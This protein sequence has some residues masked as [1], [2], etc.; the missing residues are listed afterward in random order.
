MN[1][2]A[3]HYQEITAWSK[4]PDFK[5]GRAKLIDPP[6]DNPFLGC[7][8]FGRTYVEQNFS[9]ALVMMGEAGAEIW[10][11]KFKD[12]YARAEYVEAWECPNEFPVGTAEQRR[13]A[14]RFLLR[15]EKLMH[16]AG[17]KTV[18]LCTSVSW[19]HTEDAMEF[20]P[21]LAA[22]EYLGLHEYGYPR[23]Q[24]DEV[25]TKCLHYRQL[26]AAWTAGGVKRIPPILITEC[27]ED[28]GRGHGWK[29][30]T[31]NSESTFLADLQ[32]Y[33]DELAKD[34]YLLAFFVFT[35]GPQG[36]GD[37]EITET[38]GKA[39]ASPVAFVPPDVIAP[40]TPTPI[41]AHLMECHLARPLDVHLYP[42][43]SQWFG[44]NPADYAKFNLSGHDGIDYPAPVG[45]P[46]LAA[47]A[48][49]VEQ[50]GFDAAG[51]GNFV[52]LGTPDFVTIYA[53]LSKVNVTL[54][55]PVAIGAK[56]GEVGWTGNVSPAGPGG[57]HLH[58][59]VR[60]KNGV[61]QAY[62]NWWD[63]VPFRDIWLFP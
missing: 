23:M 24:T 49:S 5:Q 34:D 21:V 37:F 59:A 50:I 58:F 27:G 61:N 28:D 29:T 41:G 57:A 31:G 20:A 3:L 48:G 14:V 26:V 11:A 62:L 39:I 10:F 12:Q 54:G 18:E 55:Q 17:Y 4:K 22:A 36:W 1:K 63:V 60:F 43:V 8:V 30:A 52:K 44:V 40:P 2:G 6:S 35:A 13:M 19:L 25:G 47:H 9:N 53:H 38:L 51:Y 33:A 42:D 45:A 15:W 56:L 16:A 46:V 7:Q 32:W